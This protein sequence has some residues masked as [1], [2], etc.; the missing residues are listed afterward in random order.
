M[1][2]DFDYSEAD[3]ELVEAGPGHFVAASRV[4]VA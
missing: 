2:P 4:A 1:D 3:S